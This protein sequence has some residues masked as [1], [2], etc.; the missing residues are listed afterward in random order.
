V[1]TIA[2]AVGNLVVDLESL[3]RDN[4][5][6]IDM[7]A[8]TRSVQEEQPL[9]SGWEER[10]DANG[11]RFYIDHNTRRTQWERPLLSSQRHSI[12][13]FQRRQREDFLR[14]LRRHISDDPDINQRDDVDDDDDNISIASTVSASTMNS[15]STTNSAP[16]SNAVDT[17]M[18]R[19]KTPDNP[20]N[21][22]LPQGWEMRVTA[23]ERPFFIDHNTH[24]T[25]WED[26]RK[27]KVLVR[28]T[29]I[30]Q[31]QSSQENQRKQSTNP[32]DPALG[33]LPAGWEIRFNETRHRYFFIDHNTHSTQWEDPRL[34]TKVKHAKAV[35][36]SRDY[37]RKYDYLR[38]QLK[39]PVR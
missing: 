9:P 26:P 29:S 27:R 24:T 20:S 17:S 16:T 8:E 1:P 23:H 35:E 38:M 21:L 2:Q 14:V 6:V 4:W 37:K 32:H 22:P 15:V 10:T 18:Q 11:R 13:D 34:A 33:L 30:P 3:Q 5:E 31:R 7:E 39:K 36:Y 28:P 19:Q 25:T 12:G